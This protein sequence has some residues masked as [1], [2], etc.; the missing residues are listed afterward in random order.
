MQIEDQMR[1]VDFRDEKKRIEKE[2]RLKRIA[3]VEAGKREA[4]IKE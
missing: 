4:I 3:D 1:V 2:Q